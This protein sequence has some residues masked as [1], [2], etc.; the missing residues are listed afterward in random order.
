MMV[1]EEVALEGML[2]LALS[3]FFIRYS[4]EVRY[5]ASMVFFYALPTMFIFKAIRDPTLKWW[6]VFTLMT[7]LGIYF[8]IYVAL[9]FVNS[10]FWLLFTREKGMLRRRWLP[11]LLS[12]ILVGL[13]LIPAY[14]LFMSPGNIQDLPSDWL[15][16][17]L[18]LGWLPRYSVGFLAW[19]WYL[20]FLALTIV[21]VYPIFRRH[22]SLLMVLLLSV[23]V[24]I[25]VIV[26]FDEMFSYFTVGR[27]FLVAL[28][29]I[30]LVA[31]DGLSY[32]IDHVELLQKKKES[33]NSLRILVFS[34]GSLLLV[35]TFDLLLVSCI[36]AL[37]A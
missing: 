32:L 8:H 6:S 34:P 7:I 10:F 29:I 37:S 15:G 16:V 4:Q 35:I 1:K 23:I 36:P 5:Y 20:S 2:F 12:G 25:T 11:F 19:G 33:V 24:Q 28:P 3:P 31:A 13:S 30:Y 22:E 9:V 21:G 26:I 27:Q 18:G 14:L 17:F